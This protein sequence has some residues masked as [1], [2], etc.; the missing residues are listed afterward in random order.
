MALNFP[1][2]PTVNQ[3]FTSNGRTWIWDGYVWNAKG[4][5]PADP[6]KIED[7]LIKDVMDAV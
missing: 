2:S 4:N 3:E 6:Q 7:N 5:V 1:D